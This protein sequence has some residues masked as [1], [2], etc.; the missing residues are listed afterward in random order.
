MENQLPLAV[1][2][3]R[4]AL[5]HA[6]FPMIVA[7]LPVA[8]ERINVHNCEGRIIFFGEFDFPNLALVVNQPVGLEQLLP[9]CL[10]TLTIVSS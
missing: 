9:A 1:R 7:A 4:V 2:H 6:S 10:P 8:P 5:A 3:L